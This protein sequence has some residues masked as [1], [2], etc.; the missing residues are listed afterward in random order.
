MVAHGLCSPGLFAL[1][2]YT[3]S[4]FSSRSIF[5]CK[6]ALSLVPRL[7]LAW[8]LFCSGNMAFPPRVGLLGEIILIFR[9]TSYYVWFIVPLGFIVFVTGVY[10][11]ILYSLIQHGRVSGLRMRGS[12]LRSRYM[13][14]SLIL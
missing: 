1:S 10:S 4:L 6:G 5:L 13:T 9:L 12:L 14:I 7:S 8:F 11:L 3:Y 2:G